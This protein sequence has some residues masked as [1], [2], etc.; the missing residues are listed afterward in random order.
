MYEGKILLLASFIGSGHKKAAEY[1]ELALKEEAPN[2]EVRLINFFEFAHPEIASAI[3]SLYF[4]LLHSKP[5]I[6]GYLYDPREGKARIADISGARGLIEG[7]RIKRA[8]ECAFDMD[9]EKKLAGILKDTAEQ[10]EMGELLQ[11]L[12]ARSEV[13][14]KI[15]NP[16]ADKIKFPYSL[17]NRKLRLLRTL[18]SYFF[19]RMKELIK[20]YMPQV[21][22][23][24]QVLPCLFVD[25]VKEKEKLGVP[26]IAILTDFGIHSWWIRPN[27]N[28]FIV[29]SSEISSTLLKKGIPQKAIYEYGI[30]VNRKFSVPKDKIGMRRKLGF[31]PELF[32]VLVMGGGTGFIVDFSRAL[33]MWEKGGLL[34]QV[35][36]VA[37]E[38]EEL[39]RDMEELR[40]KTKIPIFT[41]GFVDNVDELMAA[42]DLIITKP[43]GL[44]VSEAMASCLPMVLVR[45]IQ[46]QEENNMRFLLSKKVALDGGNGR[47]IGP[48]V[49]ELY[50]NPQ[51]LDE[52]RRRAR[53]LVYE[54]SAGNTARLI[55]SYLKTN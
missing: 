30:P 3:S 19:L 15:Y 5:R 51:K 50:R 49:M 33:R 32:T 27:V 29:P 14:Q 22:V 43:G 47:R 4:K 6:W 13:A 24:T 37:G 11:M 44:T 53:G 17:I 42:S 54:N 55:L 39:R 8:M 25:K 40:T 48:I 35:V 9:T 10:L 41:F 26:L 18:G 1:V 21:I 23:C 7:I 38:N 45:V 2:I 20:D 12:G 28:A 46:G 31:K 52:L 36:V 16:E 34:I